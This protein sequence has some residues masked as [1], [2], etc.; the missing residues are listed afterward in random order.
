MANLNQLKQLKEGIERL[1]N[2]SQRAA[3]ALEEV[4]RRLKTEHGCDTIE[5]AEAKLVQLNEKVKRE[6]EKFDAELA[7]FTKTYGASLGL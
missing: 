5:Q 3:G 7:E 1:T 4:M 2:E 6:E